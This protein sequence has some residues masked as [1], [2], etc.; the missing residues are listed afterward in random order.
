MKRSVRD[1]KAIAKLAEKKLKQSKLNNLLDTLQAQA[2][3]DE[4]IQNR[5]GLSTGDVMQNK[6]FL[7]VRRDL[8]RKR[9]KRK[10]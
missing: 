2:R 3:Q 6:C 10:I 4:Q 9:M 7:S 1:K 8:G 5:L